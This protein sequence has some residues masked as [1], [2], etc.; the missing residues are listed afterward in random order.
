MKRVLLLLV[1]TA[2]VVLPTSPAVATQAY[3]DGWS[4]VSQG[5]YRK[6]D[7][8]R[9]RFVDGHTEVRTAGGAAFTV[10]KLRVVA[11]RQDVDNVVS[12]K[13]F[14]RL[15][16]ATEPGVA[17]AA[18]VTSCEVRRVGGVRQA[19][20]VT[21]DGSRWRL[22]RPYVH[23]YYMWWACDSGRAGCPDQPPS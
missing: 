3:G 9:C 22:K 2:T 17:L 5:T 10:E 23:R 12:A 16:R 19:V 11:G 13:R 7:I 20:L 14:V 4:V 6:S 18:R 21:R 1:L 8:V 15:A